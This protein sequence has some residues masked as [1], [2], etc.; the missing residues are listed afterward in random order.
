[1]SFVAQKKRLNIDQQ[2]I[3]ICTVVTDGDRTVK[4][5]TPKNGVRTAGKP[6][7][8]LFKVN[9]QVEVHTDGKVFNVVG[10]T[11]LA[12]YAAPVTVEI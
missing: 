2:N 9:Q 11:N 4:I 7:G 6:A 10:S 3:L 8:T 12:D 5:R 1:M